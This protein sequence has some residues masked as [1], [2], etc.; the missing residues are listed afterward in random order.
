MHDAPIPPDPESERRGHELRDVA[1][2]PIVI[3]LIGLFF[4]GGVVQVAMSLLMTGYV[5]Q[6]A[7]IAIPKTEMFYDAG[8][9]SKPAAPLQDDT[10]RDM[11]QM[12]KDDKAALLEFGHNEKTGKY[13]IP[14]KRAMEIVAKKGLPHRDT[15]QSA[16]DPELPYP[17][18]T[19]PYMATP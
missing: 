3:F 9:L 17:R 2:K 14:I 11:L 8:D 19:E 4:F 5:A 7:K 16:I 10:T 18:R 1:V 12:Y 15:P 13:N 6:E